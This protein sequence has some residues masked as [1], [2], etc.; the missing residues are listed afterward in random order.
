MIAFSRCCR[1]KTSALLWIIGLSMCGCGFHLRGIIDLPPWLENVSIIIE[2]ANRDLGPM[3]V[4]QLAL[5]HVHVSPDPKQARYWIVIE[6]DQTD[7]QTASISSNTSTRQFQLVYTLWYRVQT[8]SG[9]EIIAA[10]AI[11]IN[12]QL[13][14]NSNRVL[15]SNNE[16]DQIKLEMQKEAI[17]QMLAQISHTNPARNSKQHAH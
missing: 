12:R 9:E 4:H 16:E 1:I 7:E 2:Q 10:R 14:V 5:Y 8:A 6:K 11:T 13:T 17:T 15:G 3:L